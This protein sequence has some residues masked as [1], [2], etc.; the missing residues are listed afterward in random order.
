MTRT[1]HLAFLT[2]LFVLWLP[3]QSIDAQPP[4]T[5]RRLIYE[6]SKPGFAAVT[7]TIIDYPSGPKGF[8]IAVSDKRVKTQRSFTV[9]KLQ[10]NKVWAT[11]ISSGA[12]KY[13]LPYA[14]W[15]DGDSNYLFMAGKQSY[16]VPKKEASQAVVSVATQLRA[17]AK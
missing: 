9:S 15:L 10:F 12:D 17:Y 4:I 14:Q 8:V 1:F 13:P 3:V 6:F 16:L 2:C 11:F 5:N 7:V